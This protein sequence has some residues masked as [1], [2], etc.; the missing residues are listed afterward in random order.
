M[1]VAVGAESSQTEAGGENRAGAWGRG[2]CLR[3]FAC[4]VEGRSHIFSPHP[5]VRVP[6]RRLTLGWQQD[7]GFFFLL[8]FFFADGSAAQRCAR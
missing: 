1:A 4:G 8:S 2:R 6:T 7:L 3:W 5:L